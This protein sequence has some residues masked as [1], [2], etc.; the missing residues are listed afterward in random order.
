MLDHAVELHLLLLG[1]GRLHLLSNFVRERIHAFA[2]LRGILGIA[3]LQTLSIH[4]LLDLLNHGLQLLFAHSNV[5]VGRFPLRLQNILA[6]RPTLLR[7]HLRHV[8]LGARLLRYRSNP[9]VH[10]LLLQGHA[11]SELRCLRSHRLQQLG[12]RGFHL[13]LQLPQAIH[14]VFSRRPERR[15]DARHT[16]GGGE[17]QHRFVLCKRFGN[18]FGR[19]PDVLHKRIQV[20]EALIKLLI[21]VR[22]RAV[23]LDVQL[24]QLRLALQHG[25]LRQ[26]H[27]LRH[28]H[29]V[30]D[31]VLRGDA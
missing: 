20:R 2:A 6:W 5:L 26:H 24:L 15:H 10:L 11:L 25:Q 27:L 28:V 16:L 3:F 23:Q 21:N 4:L 8:I 12:P 17:V 30:L 22:L 14:S 1:V 19:Q 18:L 13:H 7:F 31:Q 9:R 29:G